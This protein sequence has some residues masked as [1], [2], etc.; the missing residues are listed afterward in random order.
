MAEAREIL[1]YLIEHPDAKDTVDGILRWWL[2][3]G[4]SEIRKG[5]VEEALDFLVAKGFLIERETSD[6][7]KIYGV[8]RERLGEIETYLKDL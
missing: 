1:S 7:K 5:E 6:L 2:T 8:E 3:K 4:N